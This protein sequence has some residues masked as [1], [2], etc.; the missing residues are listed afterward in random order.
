MIESYSILEAAASSVGFDGL[1]PLTPSPV[2]DTSK[3]SQL[4]L[5]PGW[6]GNHRSFFPNGKF[7][8]GHSGAWPD[9][10]SKNDVP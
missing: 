1:L 10:T 2:M 4:P 6:A 3:H 8:S 7:E 9:E 5:S